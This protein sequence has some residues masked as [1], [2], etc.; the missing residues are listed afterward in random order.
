MIEYHI[1]EK[2]TWHLLPAT[3]PIAFDFFIERT[4]DLCQ[5]LDVKDPVQRG[6]SDTLDYCY[7][8]NHA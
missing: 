4:N 1:K 7:Q 8:L 2:I 3:Q 5:Y 6:Q